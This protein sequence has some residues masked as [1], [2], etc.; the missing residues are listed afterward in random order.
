MCIRDSSRGFSFL[1][2]ANMRNNTIPPIK[3]LAP[4]NENASLSGIR[5]L[6]RTTVIPP[7]DADVDASIAPK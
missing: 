6:V 5:Y 1:I 4:G 7:S 3:Y 2:M